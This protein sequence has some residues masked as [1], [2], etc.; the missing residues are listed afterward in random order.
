MAESK[1]LGMAGPTEKR[2]RGRPLGSTKNATVLSQ[3]ESLLKRTQRVPEKRGR[4][5]PR[6]IRIQVVDTPQAKVSE[7]PRN[8]AAEHEAASG[9]TS[10]KIS[11][12]EGLMRPRE[13]ADVMMSEKSARPHPFLPEKALN[14]PVASQ[15]PIYK[16]NLK[17]KYMN[18]KGKNPR[19]NILVNN[20][21]QAS[22]VEL[23]GTKRG[24][25]RPRKDTTSTGMTSGKT[26]NKMKPAGLA[27]VAIVML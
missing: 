9:N 3:I 4:G 10:V 26:Q 19:Q 8:D 18:E 21:L 27:S 6:L 2:R 24:R 14:I 1:P 16:P 5:R 15:V 23:I 13:S 20:K 17:K 12:R 11:R 25:G 7:R 22:L